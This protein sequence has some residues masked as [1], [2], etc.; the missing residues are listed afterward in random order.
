MQKVFS[1]LE[2]CGLKVLDNLPITELVRSRDRMNRANAHALDESFQI[3]EELI[4]RRLG[5]ILS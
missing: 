1:F 4:E 2:I 5:L 3:F